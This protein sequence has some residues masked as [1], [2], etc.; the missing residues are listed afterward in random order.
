MK[1]HRYELTIFLV[2]LV[3]LAVCYDDAFAVLSILIASAAF[4]VAVFYLFKAANG[5]LQRRKRD[6]TKFLLNSLILAF[7]FGLPSFWNGGAYWVAKYAKLYLNEEEYLNQI[8]KITPDSRG[9]RFHVIPW[10]GF[11]LNGVD[12][13]FDDSGEF[14]NLDQISGLTLEK[15]GYLTCRVIHLRS[16]FYFVTC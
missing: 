6:A 12:L 9:H 8:A 5:L 11:M 4:L 7:L 1:I 16:S 15:R 13:V 3:D 2:F 10:G 14:S